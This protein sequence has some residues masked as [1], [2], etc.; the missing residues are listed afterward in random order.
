[1]R[2]NK[3]IWSWALAGALA[4]SNLSG[5][6]AAPFTT[7]VAQAADHEEGDLQFN[8]ESYDLPTGDS[9]RSLRTALQIYKEEERRFVG[10]TDEVV[11]FSIEQTGDVIVLS[12]QGE[13]S[14]K[15]QTLPTT[16]AT[17]TVTATVGQKSTTAIIVVPAATPTA[18]L[19]NF[20]IANK[21]AQG[22]TSD[23]KY[24]PDS[25]LKASVTG[26]GAEGLNLTVTET[27]DITGGTGDTFAYSF[28][29]GE[30]DA[31]DVFDVNDTAGWT[32][33]DK[34]ATKDINIEV[35]DLQ[36]SA[37]G[38][39]TFAAYIDKDGEEG[40]DEEDD[41]FLNEYSFSVVGSPEG[42]FEIKDKN[43]DEPQAIDVN[44]QVQL[45][46]WNKGK[47]VDNSKLKW[48]SSSK[49]NVTVTDA[50]LVTGV[51]AGTT[52]DVGATYTIN[53]D[54]SLKVDPVEIS[55]NALPPEIE[56]EYVLT[57]DGVD[58]PMSNG[59]VEIEEGTSADVILS[60]GHEGAFEPVSVSWKSTNTSK[61]T[62]SGNEITGVAADADGIII[63]GTYKD[64][65]DNTRSV[66]FK[67]VVTEKD[68]PQ[69][70]IPTYY[71][72]G[73]IDDAI[74]LFPGDTAQLDYMN[75]DGTAI[76]G[77]ISWTVVSGPGTVDS[78][79][80]VTVDEEATAGAVIEVQASVDNIS[81]G[82]VVTITVAAD[83]Y[84]IQ[85]DKYELYFGE[86]ATLTAT[87]N[88]KP[89]TGGTFVFA[90]D[91]EHKTDFFKLSGN[92][93]EAIAATSGAITTKVVLKVGETVKGNPIE[94]K[95]LADDLK[96]ES[97]V[98]GT[99]DWNITGTAAT[100]TI[101][102]LEIGETVEISAVYGTEDL[103][104]KMK[105]SSD[106]EAIEK[107]GNGTFKAI[108][109]YV[110]NIVLKGEYKVIPQEGEGD[111]TVFSVTLTV[112]KVVL[113]TGAAEAAENIE[114]KAAE[115]D[116]NANAATKS[117]GDA[118]KAAEDAK[119][120]PTAENLHAAES[121]LEKAKSELSAAED[122]L[123]AA[124]NALDE[125]W[126]E[127]ADESK[128]GYSDSAKAAVAEAAQRVK[129]A[130]EA[131]EEA[132]DKVGEAQE[133]F[134]ELA[135]EIEKLKV[136]E[137]AIAAANTAAATAEAT[138]TEENIKAAQDAVAAAK[139]KGAQDA[140]LKEATD[141]IAKAIDEKKK[142]DEQKS[143]GSAQ[144][145]P[146]PKG[147]ALKDADGN[148]TGFVVTDATPGKATAA[149]KG[150]AADKTKK[151][152]TIPAVTKDQNGNKYTVTAIEQKAFAG[153]NVETVTAP[154]TVKIFKK[155]AFKGSKVKKVIIKVKKNAKAKDYKFNKNCFN[156][157]KKI[158]IVVKC[159]NKTLKNDVTKKFNN[160][161]CINKKKTTIK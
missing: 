136:K 94:I 95:L 76:E 155:N 64:Q 20:T 131:V 86:S 110:G 161:K 25:D 140:E 153:T 109:E 30:D 107:T 17:A 71:I 18:T 125:V 19:T 23:V 79:G 39:Y 53:N 118:I 54:L 74:S 78:N 102:S 142:Q 75:D 72:D 112:K 117:A 148:E 65:E 1:M 133:A 100:A 128:A 6:V 114:N 35:K 85:A 31:T 99:D 105:W 7:I 44:G 158:T 55:V 108:D 52:A 111:A 89:F 62:V 144:G 106:N 84:A 50:G 29:K 104:N 97:N 92:T 2:K 58:V 59:E 49:E 93:I 130:R 138:P 70:A 4:V 127:D 119:D 15:N 12:D 87:Y 66:S 73:E 101:N 46:V 150:T 160:K 77:N 38:N 146:A 82:G 47:P 37:V 5:V 116:E 34:T 45:K 57:F 98:T 22:Q 151:K 13:V 33:A 143:D 91:A 120:N 32:V 137:A 156:T 159:T 134:D 61:V 121:A 24:I 124:Q 63:T 154:N 135:P 83:V 27:Y 43:A 80:L 36:A 21:R 139:A 42:T 51:K 147:S 60:Y 90:G 157:G 123:K 8:A 10:I 56:D 113:S 67:V 11:E 40:Y 96:A 126:D 16:E 115:A 9:T 145:T 3:K 68:V 14:V 129:D 103:T 152:V 26:Y 28:T 41:L 48:S 81:V 88:G 122:A 141:K 149:Y 69:P 132:S